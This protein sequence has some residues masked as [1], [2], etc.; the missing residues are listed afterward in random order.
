MK[1]IIHINQNQEKMEIDF[2]ECLRSRVIPS[3]F[4]YWG[5]DETWGWLKVCQ[6]ERYNVF[7]KGFNFL[8]NELPDIISFIKTKEKKINFISM[9]IGN[10]LK[11]A[12]IINELS[13]NIKVSYFPIDISLDMLDAGM[14]NIAESKMDI[15]AFVSDF[16]DFLEMTKRIRDKN[17]APLLISILGNTL[18][19]FGQ[20]EI[21]NSIKRGM[22]KNDYLLMEITMRKESGSKIHGEDLTDII[23]SYNNEDFKDFAFTPLKKSGFARED[24]IVEVEYGPNQFY[25]KLSSIELWFRLLKDKVVNYAGNELVFKKDERIKLYVS[26]KYTQDNIRELLD[27]NGFEVV[28]FNVHETS[29]YGLAFSKLK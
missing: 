29:D 16:S 25:P 20:V 14:I 28:H 18:G 22:N 23:E 8:K 27:G 2:L 9:G 12:I 19:N 4:S 17:N 24:G 5:K 13:R 1:T 26:H 21:L 7:R 15:T 10:G 3:R 6:S 11:D